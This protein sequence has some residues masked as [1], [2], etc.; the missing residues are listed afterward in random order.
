VTSPVLDTVLPLPAKT[1]TI[2]TSSQP[3][4][5]YP[6]GQTFADLRAHCVL[7]VG[8]FAVICSPHY[9]SVAA[10]QQNED[11]EH[12]ILRDRR[13]RTGTANPKQANLRQSSFHCRST[14]GFIWLALGSYPACSF[15]TVTPTAQDPSS[16]TIIPM[17]LRS[18]YMAITDSYLSR[19]AYT[20]L[21]YTAW[22]LGD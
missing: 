14:K 11:V 17:I 12:A 2:A 7:V 8:S 22:R 18:R 5:T 21:F 10:L 20:S 13:I 3:P 16:S 6:S 15:V 4:V 19:Y 1:T 9:R